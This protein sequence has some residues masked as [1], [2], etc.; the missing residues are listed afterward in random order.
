MPHTQTSGNTDGSLVLHS[1]RR[2]RNVLVLTWN[3]VYSLSMGN[4]HR[5]INTTASGGNSTV[6]PLASSIAFFEILYPLSIKTQYCIVPSIF[7]QSGFLLVVWIVYLLESANI[8]LQ[9]FDS[10][11]DAIVMEVEQHFTSC[12]R[13]FTSY[14]FVL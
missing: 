6:R 10:T 13:I 14:V 9:T 8:I 4:I 7:I 1:L 5:V 11:T 12:F 3:N 2:L